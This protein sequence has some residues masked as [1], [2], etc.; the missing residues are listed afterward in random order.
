MRAKLGA[1]G[2][3]VDGAWGLNHAGPSLRAGRF[4]A[5]QVATAR[6]LFHQIEDCY[7]LAYLCRVPG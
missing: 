2:L 1:A 4:E 5:D 7:L 3:E 6:G